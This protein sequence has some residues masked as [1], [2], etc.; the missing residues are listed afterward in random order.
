[1]R[2]KLEIILFA[3]VFSFPA[4][5]GGTVEDVSFKDDVMPI[6]G[7]YCLQCHA[8]KGTQ[9]NIHLDTYDRLMKSRY[10]N[11]PS[12]MVVPGEPE[13]SR[14][15]IVVSSNNPG[16]RMPPESFG[17]NKLDES[18][19]RLIKTWILEGAKNN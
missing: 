10:F 11:K 18:D 19:I 5:C 4:A 14:L 8:G 2:I 1:M 3:L 13:N 6:L 7:D 15:Y 12:P 16:V 17:F 9:G